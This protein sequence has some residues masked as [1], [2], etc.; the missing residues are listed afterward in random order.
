VWRVR[1]C[2]VRDLASTPILE[3]VASHP[4][5]RPI[6]NEYGI[7]TCCGGRF[8]VAEAAAH[9]GIDVQPVLQALARALASR[10]GRA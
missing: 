3:L 8:S 7:D 5:L 2:R 9:D 6:L 10:P 4:E 1:I